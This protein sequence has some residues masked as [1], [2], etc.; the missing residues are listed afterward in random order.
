MERAWIRSKAVWLVCAVAVLGTLGWLGLHMLPGAVVAGPGATR[1]TAPVL[2]SRVE[3]AYGKLPISFEKNEGQAGPQVKYLAHGQNYTLFL[4]KDEAVLSL[5]G[6]AGGRAAGR[7]GGRTAK[8]NRGS[9]PTEPSM[10]GRSG[11]R[12]QVRTSVVRLRFVGANP[13]AKVVALDELPGKSNYFIGNDP[14]KWHTNVPNFARV[15]YENLYPGV[16]LMYHGDQGRFEFDMV[17]APGADPRVL[18]FNIAGATGLGL[19]PKGDLVLHVADGGVTLK[20]PTVYQVTSDGRSP[21]YGRYVLYGPAEVG[22]EVGSYDQDR[23]LVVDPTLTF[24]TLLGGSGNDGGNSIAVDGLGNVYVGGETYSSDFPTANPLQTFPGSHVGFVSKF[25]AQGTALV[26]STFFGSADTILTAIGVDGFGNAYVAGL[27]FAGFPVVNQIPGA[28]DANCIAY[29]APD[30]FVAEINAAGSGLVY[31]SLIGG[32]S[33]APGIPSGPAIAVDGAGDAYVTGSAG[34]ADFPIVNAFQPKFDGTTEPNAFI[35]KVKAAGSA[36]M[37]SSYLGGGSGQTAGVGIA[38]DSAGDAYVVG[39]TMSPSFPTVN[40]IPGAC[41]G[42]CATGTPSPVAGGFEQVFVSKVSAS[43]SNLMYSSLVGGSGVDEIG[44]TAGFP[45]GGGIAVD[46]NDNVYI[47]GTTQS[48]S[49]T[50]SD[51]FPTTAGA[52]QTSFQTSQGGCSSSVP[53]V[54]G[55]VTKINSAGTALA[56]STFLGAQDTSTTQNGTP[57]PIGIAVDSSGDADVIGFTF[58]GLP[59]LS[60]LSGQGSVVVLAQINPAGSGLVFATPLGGSSQFSQYTLSLGAI[61]LDSAGNIYVT[62]ISS[63]S[64]PATT[65]AFQTT[66]AGGNDA[67]VSKVYPGSSPAPAASF[68]PISLNFGNQIVGTSSAPQTITLANLG[69]AGLSISSINITGSLASEFSQT[70]DCGSTVAAGA[71]CAISVTFSPALADLGATGQAALTISDN[72]SNSPQSLPLGGNPI[73]PVDLSPA[74]LT[75]ASQ[76]VGT[77]SSPQPLT[78]TNNTS[79]TLTISGITISGANAGDFSQTNTCGSGIAANASCT[80]NVSFKPTASGTRVAA[81]SVADSDPSSPQT[82]SLTG[83]ATSAPA[84][85]ASLSPTSLTFGPQAQGTTSA[86]QSVTVTNSGNANL[87]FAAGAVTISGPNKADFAISADSCSGQ[88]VTAGNTCSVSVTFT[89]SAAASES[90]TLNFTDNAA[91]SPQTV[92]LS[93]TGTTAVPT[94]AVA[95]TSLT[96]GSQAQGTTSAAQTVTL[97]NSGNASLSIASITASANFSESD[98]CGSSLGAGNNCAISVKFAPTATG[99]LTGTLTVTDNNNGAANSTQTVNLSGTGTVPPDFAIAAASGT[100]T[101][102]TVSPGGTA[103]YTLNITPQNGFNQ[104]VSLACSGAPSEATCSVSPTSVT[105]NGTSASAATVTVVTTAASSLPP[106]G[107]AWPASKGPG[108]WLL[109]PGLLLL[110]ALARELRRRKFGEGARSAW[111]RRI[112][113]AGILLAVA[114]M[115]ACGGGS[116]KSSN[117]GTPAGSYTLTVTGTS[118][119]LSHSTTLSLTVN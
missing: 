51:D 83:T 55:F 96:F 66:N 1:T 74:A 35:L 40:Q 75:F 47:V 71:N 25:N 82:A 5:T 54:N 64:F 46:V 98:N 41:V 61:A 88:S 112:V 113:L 42:G 16:D 22:F 12:D 95:P 31:S 33:L 106:S 18:R 45:G 58:L 91:N 39:D 72:A 110:L 103:S 62:G 15:R 30:G 84:P 104:A 79:S 81:V 11:E 2:A 90:A 86:D 13:R 57:V 111:R 26:Y 78:L 19:S 116:N 107:P 92:S 101:S 94:A 69:S 37:Y 93:G 44:S 43:G 77:T 10:L 48:P 73:L 63:G 3:A 97:S 28:C 89:P 117:P 24:S 102:A 115:A 8:G 50:P 70:N 23:A 34:S 80:I 27:A 119:S 29:T 21:V 118:G 36:L 17:V 99:S 109:V 59:T 56:Y 105:P 38:V 100:A 9:G 14:A 32:V 65:G 114:T 20:R 76:A 6:R 53:C 4:T 7:H 108:V 68:Q 60:P 85:V 52:L 67:F 87:T 49:A